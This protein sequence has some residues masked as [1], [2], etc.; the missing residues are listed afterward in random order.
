MLWAF[1]LPSLAVGM[2][3]APLSSMLPAFYAKHTSLTLAQI[4]TALLLTRI[5][6]AFTDPAI[7]YFSDAT[8]SRFGKRKPWLFLGCITTV[9]GAQML[10]SPPPDWSQGQFFVAISLY[11]LGFTMIAVPHDAWASEL[12]SDYYERSRIFSYMQAMGPIGVILM[13]SVPLL[14]ITESSALTPET[15]KMMGYTLSLLLPLL[16][17]TTLVLVSSTPSP[18]A[19]LSL[20]SDSIKKILANQLLWRLLSFAL[21][22]AVSMGIVSAQLLFFMDNYLGIGEKMPQAFILNFSAMIMMIP[23]WLKINGVLGKHRTFA[24]SAGIYAVLYPAIFLIQPGESSYFWF[25]LWMLLLGAGSPALVVVPRSMMADIVDYDEF[26]T[27]QSRAGNYYAFQSLTDKTVSAVG[28]ST[29]LFSLSILGF[30]PKAT[31]MNEQATL[32]LVI[33]LGVLPSVLSLIAA[34]LAWTYP[35]T[36]RKHATVQKWLTRSTN[37]Q[38]C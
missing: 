22:S 9:I 14:P 2:M 17:T 23:V 38:P 19:K 29:A 18:A 34:I 15:M 13:F 6:D 33:S 12:S 30:E 36:A 10:Y 27:N 8:R 16:V 31:T 5:V 4:G 20:F 11:Y 7:G 28:A 32:A 1:S 26:K 3:A 37:R 21:V 25:M 35:F 24:L